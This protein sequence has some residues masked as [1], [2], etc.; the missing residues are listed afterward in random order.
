MRRRP[1]RPDS[2]RAWSPADKLFDETMAIANQIAS[3]S[4]PV[5]MKVK[6]AVNRAYESSLAKGLLFE[7]RREFHATFALDDQKEG[8]RIRR[9]AQAGVRHR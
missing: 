4:L 9:E 5:V 7:R 1:R 8:M 6:E 3:Y 2:S